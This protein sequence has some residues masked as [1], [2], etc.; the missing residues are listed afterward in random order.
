MWFSTAR[1]GRIPRKVICRYETIWLLKIRS[2][3]KAFNIK[4]VFEWCSYWTREVFKLVI[5]NYEDTAVRRLK[6][7][8]RMIL[9]KYFSF[10]YQSNINGNIFLWFESLSS[11]ALHNTSLFKHLLHC[12]L[13]F[14]RHFRKSKTF[15]K[16]NSERDCIFNQNSVAH[17][18]CRF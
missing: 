18:T 5:I 6:L 11:F 14:K 8:Y 13:I 10:A 2:I 12:K 17:V 15:N 9:I 4:T 3:A 7:L 1:S 16:V